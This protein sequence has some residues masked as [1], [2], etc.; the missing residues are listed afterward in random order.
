[1][2]KQMKLYKEIIKKDGHILTVKEQEDP[3]LMVRVVSTD[4]IEASDSEI[5]KA[6]EDFKLTKKCEYH[7][8]YDEAGFMYDSR[9]CGICGKFICHL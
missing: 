1:M 7:L 9:Y 4:L 5:E 8:I 6:K 3:Y 2:K